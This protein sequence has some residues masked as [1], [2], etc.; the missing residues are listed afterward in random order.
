MDLAMPNGTSE[1]RLS[2]RVTVQNPQGLHMRPGQLFVQ[3]AG[4]FESKVEVII[5]ARRIDGKSMLEILGL[6]AD[7]G[8]VLEIEASGPDAEA[9]LDALAE[10]VEQKSVNEETPN[11]H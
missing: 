7:Q 9:A 10:F 3:L 1:S 4:Q 8:T 6:G 11:Q 2:R 5:G